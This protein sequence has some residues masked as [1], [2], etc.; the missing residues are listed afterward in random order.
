M[1]NV[2]QPIAVI[3]NA[4]GQHEIKM[5]HFWPVRNPRPV[6]EKLPGNNPLTTGQRVLDALFPTV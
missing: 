2:T 3:E 1:Y 5:S 6:A 4:K